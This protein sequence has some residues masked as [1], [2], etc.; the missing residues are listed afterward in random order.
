MTVTA[1]LPSDIQSRVYSDGKTAT[2]FY[3]AVYEETTSGDACIIE[4]TQG[5]SFSNL[6]TTLSLQLVTGKT[7][8][9]V[10]WAQSPNA[11]KL[12][13]VASDLSTITVNYSEIANLNVEDTDAFW[14]M[15]EVPVTG[16]SSVTAELKRP[17]AQINVGTSDINVP[18]LAGKEI[19][20]EMVVNGVYTQYNLLTG[21][22]LDTTPTEV[23]FAKTL[24]PN[25]DKVVGADGYE[26]FPVGT[27]GQYEYLAMAYVLM[28]KD[29]HTADIDL[30]FYDGDTRFHHLDVDGAPLQRNYRT[31]I[32]GALL[33][34]DIDFTININ[35]IYDGKYNEE[36]T[37]EPLTP[38]PTT[39]K[40]NVS[41]ALDL[42][43]LGVTFTA[44]D[45][46]PSVYNTVEITADI[47]MSGFTFVPPFAY[48]LTINGNGHTIKNL[49][50]TQN[51]NGR[52]GFVAYLGG[53]SVNDLVLE[54]VTVEGREAGIIAGQIEGGKV[55]NVTIKGDCSV[56]FIDVVPSSWYDAEWD[57]IGALCGLH[58]EGSSGSLTIDSD[59]S[60]K[61]YHNG[62]SNNASRVKSYDQ[63]AYYLDDVKSSITITNNGSIVAVWDGKV[64]TPVAVDGAY[65]V[66][67]PGNW[68]WFGQNYNTT[69][70][71][72]LDKGADILCDLDF[73][74]M[75]VSPMHST[76]SRVFEGNNHTM[77]NIV[78]GV[79][80]GAG[81]GLFVFRGFTI[82]NLTI[83]NV[84]CTQDLSAGFSDQWMGVLGGMLQDGNCNANITNVTIDGAQIN[85]C[86]SVGGFVGRVMDGSTVTMNNCTIKNST[87]KNQ[88]WANECGYVG[89]FVGCSRGVV[90]GDNNVAENVTV[91]GIYCAKRGEQSIQQFV[92]YYS[93]SDPTKI[94]TLTNS[95]WGAGCTLTVTN[96]DE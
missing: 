49:N 44:A 75:T 13:D 4:K 94:N 52:A 53:G 3:Y 40:Y 87:V 6:T 82:Q 14:C 47:D 39:G 50:I 81:S 90:T 83:K 79:S 62:L 28:A 1:T 51:E 31:N 29:K 54:N 8:K 26:N 33:T 70:G 58:V 42:M 18:A 15:K 64:V 19:S 55:N 17:F 78:L 56:S 95:T 38:D 46:N 24:R 92:G 37:V 30:D 21:D 27:S 67:C 34:S 77:S 22:V 36:I 7:Y 86:Q 48:H 68:E 89:T 2:D 65:Q 45:V 5:T 12:F 11:T 59:C 88:Y 43:S 73:N 10:F 35:P 91:D 74:G 84:S 60:I 66:V 23:T 76:T 57:G 96:G 93:T 72:I 71:V 25:Q 41:S 9:M 85:G 61:L 80:K 20:T 63:M 32:F 69:N 16:S